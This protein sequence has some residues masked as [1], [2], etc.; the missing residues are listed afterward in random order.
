M[1]PFAN[2]ITPDL[3]LDMLKRR[4]W[5]ALAVFSLVIAGVTSVTIS[6]PN[7]YTASASILVEGQQIPQEYVRTTV[8]MG[9][10]RRLQII[11]QEILSRTRIQQLVQQFNL[12]DN[13]REHGASEDEIVT[14]MRRDIG[15]QIKG[16]GGPGNDSTVVFE[17]SYTSLDPK[18]VMDVANTIASFYIE[19][20]LKVREQQASGTLEFLRSELE[21]VETKLQEQEQQ[22]VEYK[23]RYMGELPE[24]LAA[25]LS[26]LA[27]LQRQMEILSDNLARARERQNLLTREA[28]VDIPLGAVG[29]S[30]IRE[31]RLTPLESLKRQL[32]E[33]KLRFSDKHPDVLRLKQQIMVLE[34]GAQ[35]ETERSQGSEELKSSPPVTKLSAAQV[36]RASLDGEIKTLMNNLSEV[37]KDISQY[38]Q[39]VENAPKREQELVSI[40]RDY[41]ST[42]GLYESLLKRLEEAKLADSLE[43]R[44]KAERFRLLEPATYP[45]QPA[46][47]GRR[48]L[49]LLGVVLS[50][51]AAAA[52]VLL[53]EL[54]DTSVH[55]VEDL[56]T[57]TTVRILGAVPNI[58]TEADRLSIFRRRAVGSAAFVMTLLAVVSVSYRVAA[59]NEQFVR[60]LV[61][62]TSSVPAR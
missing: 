24:Q 1:N 57:L 6:L 30:S 25:N 15:M 8:T 37:Q 29:T 46:G 19:G 21:K 48:R 52:S 27:V 14:A 5:L 62:P 2:G 41:N 50:I 10:E 18:Q 38:K 28:E 20:N 32:A 40:T 36:E 13:L 31:P 16:R 3:V 43:Q 34:E 22:V 7:M 55:R 12:Y 42:K 53:R 49:L 26:T 45:Q 51:G 39:R 58:V 56:R 60:F 17:V 47:P 61:Q 33:L 54:L 35:K 44:Q 9:L 4:L 23:K 59:G 11:S